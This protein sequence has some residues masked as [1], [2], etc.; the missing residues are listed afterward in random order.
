MKWTRIRNPRSLDET[1]I[2]AM[3]TFEG[4]GEVPFTANPHDRGGPRK[5]HPRCDPVRGARTYRPG[6][7]DAGEGPAGRYT[8]KGKAGYPSRY[9]L[10]HGSSRRAEAAG[11]RNHGRTWADSSSCFLEAA[12]SRLE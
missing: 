4:I 6:R 2:H 8:S 9:P 3:V 12:D 10:A 5:G 1:N 11:Y 7:F